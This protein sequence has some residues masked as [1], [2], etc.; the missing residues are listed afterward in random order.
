MRNY[1]QVLTEDRR[2]VI[3]RVLSELN[4]Y[5]ANSSVIG[6]LLERWGHTP[7]RDQIK[8]DLRWLEEQGLLSIEEIESVLLATLTER[9]MD[10]AKGRA[11]QPG[12]KRPGA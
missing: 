7:S 2:L 1:A 4:A 6:T 10:V 12:V 8:T 3:L 5:K 9:G 11:S